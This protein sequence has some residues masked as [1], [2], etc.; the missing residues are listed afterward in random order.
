VPAG[1][2]PAPAT[3]TAS[4]RAGDLDDLLDGLD[5]GEIEPGDAVTKLRL[6][7]EGDA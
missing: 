5:R 3:P 4:D 2:A 7:I 1:V 6:L